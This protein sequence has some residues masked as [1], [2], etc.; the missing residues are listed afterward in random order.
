[1]PEFLITD[2]FVGLKTH[3]FS[4]VGDDSTAQVTLRDIKYNKCINE[5]YN[6][7]FVLYFENLQLC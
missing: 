6:L 7:N 5:K 2:N 4:K 3:L 1:M